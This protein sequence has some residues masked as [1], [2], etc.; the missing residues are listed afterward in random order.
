V[1]VYMC[2]NVCMHVCACLCVC[3]SKYQESTTLARQGRE[4]R[5]GSKVGPV[6]SFYTVCFNG[7]MQ[8]F[9]TSDLLEGS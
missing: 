4:W 5:G 8:Y 6:E 2:V 9:V 1:F 3:V 7:F